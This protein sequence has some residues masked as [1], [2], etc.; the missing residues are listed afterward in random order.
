[1]CGVVSIASIIVASIGIKELLWPSL[2]VAVIST[3][4]FIGCA[5]YCICGLASINRFTRLVDSAPE[6]KQNRELQEVTTDGYDKKSKG[7]DTL[8][9]ALH[10]SL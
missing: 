8:N 10:N 6:E 4:G 3:L 5:V 1:M 2:T 9:L 7:M